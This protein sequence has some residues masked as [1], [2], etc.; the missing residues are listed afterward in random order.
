MPIILE[1][2][3]LRL[4]HLM[5]Q[6][7]PLLRLLNENPNVYRYTGDGPLADDSAALEILVTRIFPHYRD[8]GVGRWA[9]ELRENNALVF[10]GWCGLRWDAD[11]GNYDIGYRF[12][13]H[14]WGQGFAT[15]AARATLAWGL[16]NLPNAPIIARARVENSAS[17]RVLEKIGMRLSHHEMDDDG[18]VAVYRA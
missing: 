1:T 10:I 8:Y 3:R 12:F 18:E 16:E 6:D 13:E 5:E 4:R 7:A 11:S 14:R 2:P 9:V 17:L 15:E